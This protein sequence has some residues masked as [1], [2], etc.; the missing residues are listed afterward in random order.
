MEVCDECNKAYMRDF[1]CRNSLRKQKAKDHWTGRYCTVTGCKGK[2][3]DTIINFGESLHQIPL[4]RADKES[5]KCDVMLCLGSSLTV[6][7]AANCPKTV[8]IKAN[9]WSDRGKHHLVI[10]NLQKTPLHDNLC[11]LP[12][13]AKIDDVMTGLMK[14]LEMDNKTMCW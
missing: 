11:T 3:H 12:I 8:G 5:D 2:L 7:P 9:K 1:C 4:K 13:F 6:Y 10:V 14:E